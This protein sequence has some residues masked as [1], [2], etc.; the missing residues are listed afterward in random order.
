MD[1]E[2][3]FSDTLCGHRGLILVPRGSLFR[4]V[5]GISDIAPLSRAMI[6][7]GRTVGVISIVISLRR[8]RLVESR[9][10]IPRRF[11]PVRAL[12]ALSDSSFFLGG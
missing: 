2:A 3:A 8:V 7:G 5:W 9:V 12:V 1:E 6:P 11:T 4:F 10:K